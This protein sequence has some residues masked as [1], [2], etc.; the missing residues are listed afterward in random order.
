MKPKIPFEK[1]YKL[2]VMMSLTLTCL[3]EMKSETEYEN[4]WWFECDHVYIL[5]I[6]WH[7]SCTFTKKNQSRIWVD[8]MKSEM[9][10][11]SY[12]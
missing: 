2:I 5:L 4:E 11:V 8:V 9:M 7:Y 3:N 10:R 1:N 12:F 6:W